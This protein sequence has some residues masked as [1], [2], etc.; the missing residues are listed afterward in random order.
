MQA[1]L[2]RG[3]V[4][5][6][7]I[8]GGSMAVSAA[9]CASAASPVGGTAGEAERL[10]SLSVGLKPIVAADGEADEV[11]AT[12]SIAARSIEAGSPVV[13]LPL[14]SGNVL[15]AATTLAGLDARDDLGS[16]SLAAEDRGDDASGFRVWSARR[17]VRGTL[18]L[19]YRVPAAGL[20][21]VR[22]AGTPVEMRADDNAV[23]GSAS[24]F[25]LLPPGADAFRFSLKWD[26]SAFPTGSKAL[27]SFGPGDV[28]PRNGVGLEAIRSSFFMAGRIGTFPSPGGAKGFNAAWQ[29]SLP[30]PGEPLMQW[31]QS[32]YDHY[33]QL[34]KR[35]PEEPYSVFVRY[36][37]LNGG[38]GV[39]QYRSFVLTY[40]D[41][42]PANEDEW[43]KF[44]LAHEMYHTFQPQIEAAPGTMSGSWFNEGTAVFYGWTLPHR[45]GL[46]GSDYLLSQVNMSAMRYYTSIKAH[47]SNDEV[48]K[49]FWADT[50]IRMLAYDRGAFYFA[51]VDQ[52]IRKRSAGKRSLDDLMLVLKEREKAKGTLTAAD[53]ESV[54]SAELG[55]AAVTDFRDMLAGKLQLPGGD[56]FG[57]CFRRTSKM[58]RRYELGFDPEVLVE[59]DRIVR[60]LVAGSEAEKAGLRNGDRL[61]R[62]VPQDFAASSQTYKL[63]Y[64]V[65]RGSEELTLSYLPRGEAVA[66]PQWERD[67]DAPAAT[68][69]Q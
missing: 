69:R 14:V 26:L 27:S 61:V 48:A 54:V 15:T 12:I 37:P 53:W 25:L 41:E 68:C 67:P 33:S 65:R 57:P 51:L 36:N 20:T 17:A 2:R 21:G 63:T 23:S 9:V 35:S 22:G 46:S 52:A 19:K 50:R 11:E 31:T 44:V 8:L 40:K 49:N 7:Y 13:Q 3:M 43:L 58:L 28:A 18:V 45:F 32:L 66:T 24:T 1:L 62:P 16:L 5:A 64:P 4:R 60:G 29:G 56:V 34:Y 59:K 42:W 30:V 39:G 10:P 47:L 55:A 38:G 6:R